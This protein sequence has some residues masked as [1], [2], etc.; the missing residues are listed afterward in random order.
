[1]ASNGGDSQRFERIDRLH[2]VVAVEE[3]RRRA[4]RAQPVAVDDGI[5]RRLDQPDVL[6]ADAAHLVAAPLG[7]AAHVAGVLGQRAD[8]RNREQR[9]QLV[10][11]PIAVDVDEID[12]VVHGDMLQG[13][14]S[15][16][17]GRGLRPRA[18]RLS[19]SRCARTFS[20][21]AGTERGRQTIIDG[22]GNRRHRVAAGRER[23]EDLPFAHER[24]SR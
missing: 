23:V 20:R 4:G 9:L 8:A 22:F 12:D 7:A 14:H 6:Q 17:S 10:E 2:V 15:G 18:F 3:D 5:A 13:S 19:F 21:A 11:V 1:M 24:C 16:A